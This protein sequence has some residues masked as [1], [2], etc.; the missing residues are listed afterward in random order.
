MYSLFAE[1]QGEWQLVYQ[2]KSFEDLQSVESMLL[3]EI[4]LYIGW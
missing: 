2:T 4:T 3:F 1:R